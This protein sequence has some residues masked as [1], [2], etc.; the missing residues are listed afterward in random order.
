[1][2]K[3]LLAAAFGI[4]LLS[5]IFYSCTKDI[6]PN[7]LLDKNIG[8]SDKA[9]YDTC[10]N[11]AAFTYYKGNNVVITSNPSFGSPHGNFK[12]KFNK[13]ATAALGGDGKLPTGQ[14]FP[15]GS[16][17]LKETVGGKYYFTFKRNGSWL[18]GALIMADGSVEQSVNTESTNCVSCHMYAARDKIYSFDLY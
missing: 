13:V 15:D 3:P 16:M 14:V 2:K 17:V 8:Y 7:P 12:L 1:M 9:L 18:W 6:G 11:E 5:S 10:K 4:T